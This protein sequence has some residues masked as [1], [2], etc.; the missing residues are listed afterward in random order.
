M[1]TT[2]T[3]KY[4]TIDTLAGKMMRDILAKF[5][6]PDV[7]DKENHL[8]QKM[9][10]DYHKLQSLSPRDFISLIGETKGI[11]GDDLEAVIEQMEVVHES[12]VANTMISCDNFLGFVRFYYLHVSKILDEPQISEM[13]TYVSTGIFSNAVDCWYDQAQTRFWF[14][15]QFR[16]GFQELLEHAPDASDFIVE[17]V[18]EQWTLS[19]AFTAMQAPNLLLEEV[20][21]L[22]KKNRAGVYNGFGML[23]TSTL[24]GNLGMLEF[25]SVEDYWTLSTKIGTI[26]SDDWHDKC[27]ICI[28]S[29]IK[30][31]LDESRAFTTEEFLKLCNNLY[32][33]K[34]PE[35]NTRAV[36]QIVGYIAGKQSNIVASWKQ[37]QVEDLKSEAA[38]VDKLRQAYKV[39]ENNQPP[40]VN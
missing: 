17:K 32:W 2:K 11:D 18:Q 31:A 8:A 29:A 30:K 20:L 4:N 25:M 26:D 35:T 1:T 16:K 37:V 13:L 22:F 38:L 39:L 14:A 24:I 33:L 6:Y 5:V 19:V 10:N 28:L 12:M 40:R 34:L 23:E 3:V 36:D 15:S 9:K 21:N 7:N 27:V